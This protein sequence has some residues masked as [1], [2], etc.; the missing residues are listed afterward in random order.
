VD[1]LDQSYF[2]VLHYR[3]HTLVRYTHQSYFL[4]LLAMLVLW[5]AIS[6]MVLYYLSA[7][8]RSGI[9]ER[10]PKVLCIVYCALY[11]ALYNT[12]HNALGNAA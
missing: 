1:V 8:H 2:L 6:G 4:V 7:R 12:Q 11:C 5:T 10:D 3:S 9:H